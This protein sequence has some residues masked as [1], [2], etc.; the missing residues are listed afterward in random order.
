L[1]LDQA[2]EKER[3]ALAYLYTSVLNMLFF[4]Y[5]QWQEGILSEKEVTEWL[6]NAPLL[7]APYLN[8]LWPLACQAYPRYFQGWVEDRYNLDPPSENFQNPGKRN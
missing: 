2:T 4:M 5:L 8:S 6:K 7:R 1:V 3:I